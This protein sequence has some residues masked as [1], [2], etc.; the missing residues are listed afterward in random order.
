MLYEPWIID[1]EEKEDLKSNELIISYINHSSIEIQ[2]DGMRLIIDPWLTGPCYDRS[3][4][5]LHEID[6]DWFNRIANADG[7]FL[8]KS[9]PDHF[10]LPTLRSIAKI[11]PNIQIY[12]PEIMIN[13][14]KTQLEQ[15]G[16]VNI[17][18]IQIGIWEIFPN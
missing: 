9:S 14:F 11:N 8:S 12:I 4:W 6:D 2:A 15:L 5:L 18:T 1:P 16:F 17:K 3:W 13:L 7:I 10:N